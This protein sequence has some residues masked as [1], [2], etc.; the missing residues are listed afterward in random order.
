MKSLSAHFKWISAVLAVLIFFSSTGLTVRAH[1]CAS[2][3][4]LIKSIFSSELSCEHDK[5]DQTSSNETGAVQDCCH[6]KPEKSKP[7]HDCC[8]DFR[9][10]YQMNVDADVSVVKINIC[11]FILTKEIPSFFTN[12][13]P[14][15]DLPSGIKESEISTPLLSGIK[16]LTSLHQLKIDLNCT[17]V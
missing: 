5:T 6:H 14:E 11:D 1:Y 4:T 10:Y 8:T 9:Q 15:V 12:L 3:H 2:E 16:L 13:L 17:I 7:K